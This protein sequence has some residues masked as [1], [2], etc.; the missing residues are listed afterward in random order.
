VTSR[1][2]FMRIVIG[3][4]MH[5]DISDAEVAIGVSL[6]YKLLAALPPSQTEVIRQP[7]SHAVQDENATH[8]VPR[9]SVQYLA[10]V[11]PCLATVKRQSVT[12]A[13]ARSLSRS[14]GCSAYHSG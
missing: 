2:L 4:R 11:W 13:P 3:G 12:T 14:V 5:R 9:M 6:C 8:R 10:L 7:R 1:E